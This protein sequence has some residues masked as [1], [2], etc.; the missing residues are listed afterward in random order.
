MDP[1]SLTFLILYGVVSLTNI[2]FCIIRDEKWRK[3]TKLFCMPMLMGFVLSINYQNYWLWLSLL[4]AWIG[5]VLFIFKKKKLIAL[6]GMLFFLVAHVFYIFEF[7]H[8]F[9]RISPELLN[10]YFF[11]LYFAPL[12]LLPGIPVGLYLSKKDIKLTIAGSF[13]QSVLF[14]ILGSSIFAIANNCSLY[15]IMIGMGAIL[16]YVSDAFNAY[17]L[18]IKKLKMRE[19]II[20]SSYLIAQFLIVFGIYL[21][22]H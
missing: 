5:D 3:I 11:F 10:S 16:Y 15:F 2:F 7:A 20:M 6:I 19:L 18:Y 12:F 1:L 4:F 22:A 21:I 13:Y 9:G 17:T 8:L 14:L